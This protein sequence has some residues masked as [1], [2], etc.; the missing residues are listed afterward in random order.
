MG[1]LNVQAYDSETKAILKR[2][3]ILCKATDT[4]KIE[5]ISGWE[6]KREF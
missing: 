1:L 3:Q 6:G 4:H 2:K 5:K